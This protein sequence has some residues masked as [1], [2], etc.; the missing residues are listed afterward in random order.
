MVCLCGRTIFKNLRSLLDSDL[1]NVSYGNWQRFPVNE[2]YNEI[3]AYNT[4]SSMLISLARP[5]A[6][7]AVTLLR[8]S[9]VGFLDEVQLNDHVEQNLADFLTSEGALWKPDS[10]R[11]YY[12]MA[13]PLLDGFIRTTLIPSQFP[14]SPSSV[15]PLEDGGRGPHVLGILIESLK[16]FDK[17]L[18]CLA[19]SR[20]YKTSKVKIPGVPDSR[21]PRESVY[22]TELMRILSNWLRHRYNWTV[23]GQWHLQTHM[24]NHKYS[25]IVIKRK[26]DPTIVL[27]LLA[28]GDTSF[29]RSH[30]QKT[31]EYM[32]LLSTKEAWVVH[33]TCERDYHP[34]WQSDVELSGGVNVVHFA[35][36]LDFTN[37]VM[38]TR[39]KDRAGNIHHEARRLTV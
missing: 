19:V 26:D 28:T 14:D 22:D 15:P 21:V 35:H 6:A 17:D 37:V 2:L 12:C 18:I 23:T 16:F 38:S 36:D 32:A 30:I 27:E 8:S 5:Q 31:P 33:F 3:L 7:A 10:V 34:I 11:P 1:L 29:V 24:K 25:D 9:F 20:S 13:S 4:F 39:W